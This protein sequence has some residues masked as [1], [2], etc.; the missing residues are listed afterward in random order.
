[1]KFLKSETFALKLEI[2]IAIMLGI[3]AVL[4]AWASWQASLYDGNQTSSYAAGT[5][6]IADAKSLYNE[7][8]QKFTQDMGVWNKIVDMRIEIE[9]A[10][11]KNNTEEI[12]RYQ[13]KLYQLMADNVSDTF[14]EALQWA[15]AQTEYSS[16]FD[17]E[18]F[19]DSYYIDAEATYDAG[20]AKLK[21][22]E[23][24]NDLGDR[25]G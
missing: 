12:E 13:W 21:E 18:D 16:P 22:G 5:A 7:G 8:Y 11:Q 24:S 17:K 15:D 14:S 19:L 23:N 6:T 10:T 4:T 25:L 1:M 2:I 3:T 20:Q 9:Y